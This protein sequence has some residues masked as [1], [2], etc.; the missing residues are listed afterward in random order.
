MVPFTLPPTSA[1][2]VVVKGLGTGP[3]ET[4]FVY[5]HANQSSVQ[6]G[7]PFAIRKT[8]NPDDIQVYWM[9]RSLK[10]VIWPYEFH[11]YTADW[12]SSALKYQLYVRGDGSVLGP[13]VQSRKAERQS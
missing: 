4:Q 3:P 11:L 13:N 5:Q 1:P 8:A 6:F 2:P 7:A 9:S 12:P 10:N